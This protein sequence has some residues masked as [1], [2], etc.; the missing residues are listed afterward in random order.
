MAKKPRVVLNR[1]AL[2]QLDRDFATGLENL[3]ADALSQVDP[4]D[5]APY[6]QGLIDRFG[7]ISYVDGKKVGADPATVQKPRKMTVRGKGIAVG[8]GFGFP[9]RF[10]ETGTV[11]Q[12]PRPFFAPVVFGVVGD[13]SAVL[14]ALQAALAKSLASKAR[15][16]TR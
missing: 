15:R 1:E 16:T 2:A 9:G 10:Q 13:G 5:A 12:P 14:S 3:A 6:G 8:L 4:P 11:N 7:W